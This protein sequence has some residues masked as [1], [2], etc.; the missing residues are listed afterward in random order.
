M[1]FRAT[2]V[3]VLANYFLFVSILACCDI[4]AQ[5]IYQK[6]KYKKGFFEE[7]EQHFPVGISY[8][9]HYEKAFLDDEERLRGSSSSINVVFAFVVVVVVRQ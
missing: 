4:I 5:I 8:H 6:I 7:I 9:N 2:K 1:P 3:L